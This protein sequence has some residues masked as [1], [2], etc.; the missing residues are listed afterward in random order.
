M[1]QSNILKSKQNLS[2]VKKQ[3]TE[4]S[5]KQFKQPY[6]TAFKLKV[7]EQA[8]ACTALGEIGALLR[9]T[10]VSST[11]LH[12]WRHDQASEK[13]TCKT[14]DQSKKSY[15]TMRMQESKLLRLEREI[16]KLKAVIELQKK[17]S[18]FIT[19]FQDKS[20]EASSC[21]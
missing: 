16:V 19:D 4:V 2:S 6:T 14:P 18:E 17:I 10:G 5:I 15:A 21:N 13:L 1:N 3:N 11:S 12:R 8:A 7:L 9:K 20:S